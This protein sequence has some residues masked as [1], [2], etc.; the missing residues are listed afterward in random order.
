MLYEQFW[1]LRKTERSHPGWQVGANGSRMFSSIRKQNIEKLAAEVLF[2][3]VFLRCDFSFWLVICIYRCPLLSMGDW[4]QEPLQILKC[5]DAQDPFMRW[6]STSQPPKA[7]DAKPW[8]WRAD[9][10]TQQQ[11]CHP[12]WQRVLQ[13]Q[14][15]LLVINTSFEGSL[16]RKRD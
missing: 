1:W 6:C 2:H 7:T 12:R 14:G 3:S 4:F 16:L 11:L 15:L 10:S 13:K 5:E 9:C 8:I